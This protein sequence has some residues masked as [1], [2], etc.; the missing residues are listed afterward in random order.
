VMGFDSTQIV[1]GD[2]MG[3]SQSS[4]SRIVR[5]VSFLLARLRPRFITFP[6][7]AEGLTELK[8]RF[9]ELGRVRNWQGLPHIIGAIDGCHVPIERPPAAEGIDPESFRNRKGYFSINVQVSLS[10]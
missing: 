3:I 4:V 9:Q 10:L 1:C 7:T 6:N 2:L 8:E 5:R